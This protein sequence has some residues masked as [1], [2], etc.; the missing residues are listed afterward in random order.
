MRDARKFL[1]AIADMKDAFPDGEN[2][3]ESIQ[4]KVKELANEP[5]QSELDALKTQ[6]QQF[7][8][9]IE[10][11]DG[12]W[13]TKLHVWAEQGYPEMLRIPVS[14]LGFKNGYGDS[15]LMGLVTGA[16]GNHTGDIDYGFIQQ[17]LDTPMDYEEADE[18]GSMV[19]KNALVDVTDIN[20]QSAIDF[21]VDFA[22]GTGTY[23][24]YPADEQ[25]KT[26]LN[27]FSKDY[28]EAADKTPPPS[29]PPK[30]DPLRPPQP[31]TRMP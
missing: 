20:G 27:E 24:G 8:K 25:L 9:Q 22:N 5:T 23:Q 16:C 2:I 26:I 13:T 7:L 3:L 4:A 28:R 15:V 6:P 1:S 21:L 31:P 12:G 18:S 11:D 29:P 14:L 10:E 17:I 30:I 19:A